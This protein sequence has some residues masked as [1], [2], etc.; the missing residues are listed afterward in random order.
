[1]EKVLWNN[2]VRYEEELHRVKEGRNIRHAAK[3]RKDN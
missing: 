2:R 1:V 3:R